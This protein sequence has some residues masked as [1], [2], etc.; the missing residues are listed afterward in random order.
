MSA[1]AMRPSD[2]TVDS[3]LSAPPLSPGMPDEL[4]S[5]TT[6]L[7]RQEMDNVRQII[8]VRGFLTYMTMI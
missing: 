2:P 1:P 4:L 5:S 6:P 7:E 3:P 8:Q